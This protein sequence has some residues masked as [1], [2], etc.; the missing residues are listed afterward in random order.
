MVPVVQ[1]IV[2]DLDNTLLNAKKEIS[3][4]YRDIIRRCQEKGFLFAFATARPERAT[5]VLR[6]AMQP[7]YILAN[8]G[9]TIHRIDK[10][11]HQKVIE[12][13][14]LQ[15]LLLELTAMPDVTH[16]TVEAGDCL[17]ANFA[18]GPWDNENWNLTHHSFREPLDK[19][20]PKLSVE[21]RN[22]EA[23]HE[24]I[25]DFPNLHLYHNSGEDWFQIMHVDASKMNAIRYISSLMHIPVQNIAA[26]GDDFND[27]DMIQNCGIGIAVAG[28]TEAVKQA[29]DGI[30]AGNHEDGVAKWL[31][32]HLL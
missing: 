22:A 15:R 16:I 18:G 23:L 30:C 17:Y 29:A 8:N 4:Y 10:V 3:P 28:A 32:E 9:A 24:L 20:V 21:S 13:D 6:G 5:H 14:V 2:T 11:I 1:L 31:S 7:D 27:I 26:F 25:S 12:A 19:P